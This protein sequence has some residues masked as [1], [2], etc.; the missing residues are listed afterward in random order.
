MKIDD[1]NTL[2]TENAK[3]IQEISNSSTTLNSLTD[4]LNKKLISFHT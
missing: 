2:S 3:G 1:I 4:E